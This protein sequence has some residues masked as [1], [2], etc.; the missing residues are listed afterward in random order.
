[1]QPPFG[2]I[3]KDFGS[4]DTQVPLGRPG[5][6]VGT[7]LLGTWSHGHWVPRHS[8]EELR[9]YYNENQIQFLIP[10]FKVKAQAEVPRLVLTEIRIF[11]F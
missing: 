1:L 2:L 6:W 5:H 4:P 10:C 9:N 11:F 8:V 7:R 3:W